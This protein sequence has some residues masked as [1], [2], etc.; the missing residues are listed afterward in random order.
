MERKKRF[1]HLHQV[2]H[3]E[4]FRQVST[5]VFD[6]DFS[7]PRQTS[8]N[9]TKNATESDLVGCKTSQLQLDQ[10]AIKFAIESVC[11]SSAAYGYYL[12]TI[13]RVRLAEFFDTSDE[14]YNML[15]TLSVHNSQANLSTEA[16][17]GNR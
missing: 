17:H 7:S 16:G 1:V 4:P 10:V 6:S 2:Q 14:H 11:I 13:A 9:D 15:I 5:L 8:V 12:L 3:T